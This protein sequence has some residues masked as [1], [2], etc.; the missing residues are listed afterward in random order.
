VDDQ[1]DRLGVPVAF[2]L[3]GDDFE[4]AA[5]L[6]V[7]DPTPGQSALRGGDTGRAGVRMTKRAELRPIRCRRADWVNLISTR[8]FCQTKPVMSNIT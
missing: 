4:P 1:Q 6:V 7:A 3:D 2:D 8:S 5:S